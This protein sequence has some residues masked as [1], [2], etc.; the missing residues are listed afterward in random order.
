MNSTIGIIAY[1]SPLIQDYTTTQLSHHT[2]AAD[3]V[4]F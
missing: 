3:L 2:K 4:W 1:D